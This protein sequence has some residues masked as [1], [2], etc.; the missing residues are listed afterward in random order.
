[1]NQGRVS[2]WDS[3]FIFIGSGFE[4][5]GGYLG[6]NQE[7]L[8]LNKHAK[9]EMMMLEKDCGRSRDRRKNK[10]TQGERGGG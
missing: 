7:E 6:F 9:N 1:M 8:R 4:V 5:I 3:C 10:T 2:A